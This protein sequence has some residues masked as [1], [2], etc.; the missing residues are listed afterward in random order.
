MFAGLTETTAGLSNENISPPAATHYSFSLKLKLNNSKVRVDFKGIF[1]KQDKV[2]FT[3]KNIVKLYIAYK[4]NRRSLIFLL[5]IACL[6]V[7]S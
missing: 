4:L 1:L 2:T 7:L 6:E 5:K 3:R